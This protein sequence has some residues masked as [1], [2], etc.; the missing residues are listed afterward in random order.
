MIYLFGTRQQ[1]IESLTST[2]TC[3]RLRALQPLCSAHIVTVTWH[4]PIDSIDREL[5]HNK[6]FIAITSD[7]FMYVTNDKNIMYTCFQL[8]KIQ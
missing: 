2:E 1:Y 8:H 4:Y 6:T 3:T 5:S 7:V